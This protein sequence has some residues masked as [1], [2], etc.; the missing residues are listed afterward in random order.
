MC[1]RTGNEVGVVPG[2]SDQDYTQGVLADKLRGG[3]QD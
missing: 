2:G 1:K 3:Q